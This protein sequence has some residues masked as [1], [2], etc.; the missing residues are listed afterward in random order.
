MKNLNN[1]GMA[2]A[3]IYFMVVLIVLAV[4]YLALDPAMQMFKK[5]ATDTGVQS[6]VI[7]AIFNIGWANAPIVF[8]ASMVLVLFVIALRIQGTSGGM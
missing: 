7:N 3:L 8:I 5:Q 1:K 2:F 6:G 4:L